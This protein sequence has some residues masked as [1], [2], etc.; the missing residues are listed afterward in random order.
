MGIYVGALIATLTGVLDDKYDLNP[1]LRI[2]LQLLAA[3]TV[4]VSGVGI[5]Y[6]TNPFGGL[7]WLDQF[8]IVLFGQQL[9]PLALFF[10]L[11]WIVWVMNM[12]NWSNGVDGQ[13][14]MI[15]IGRAHV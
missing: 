3:V 9:F 6:L 10:A 12:V 13:F 5:T 14:P 2:F 15:E 7:L 8:K 4:L 1:Y 11:T